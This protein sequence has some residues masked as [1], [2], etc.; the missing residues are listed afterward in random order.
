MLMDCER[1]REQLGWQPHYDAADTLA[2]M[3]RG[4]REQDVI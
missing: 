3:I 2:G 1:A 4:A